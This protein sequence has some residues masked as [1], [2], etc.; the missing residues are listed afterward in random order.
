VTEPA[1]RAVAARRHV[2][3]V[4]F[5]HGLLFA[6]WTAHIPHLQARL[7]LSDAGLG[8]ALLGAPIGSVLAVGSVA[9]LLTRLGSRRTVQLTLAGYSLAG[10]LVAVAGSPLALAAGLAVWG[11]CQGALDVS[12]NTQG[13]AVERAL[14]RPI[15]SGLHAGWSLGAF[16]GAG[17]GALAVAAGVSLTVQLLVLGPLAGAVALLMPGRLL[18]DPAPASGAPATR[19]GVAL[20]SGLVWLLGAIALAGLLCEG[21]AADWSAVELR[22]VTGAVPGIAGLGYAAFAAAMFLVRVAGDRLLDR[23][24]PRALVPGLLIVAA[25]GM[26]VALAVRTPGPTLAGLACLGAGIGLVSPA[27]FSAAG[28]LPGI[29]TGT[30]VA[31]VAAI[32]WTGF[33]GGP[34]LIGRLAQISSLPI[35]L[36]LVP[37][38]CAAIAVAIRTTDA[39]APPGSDG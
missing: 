12:M 30:G 34:P 27:A 33:V 19:R 18:A 5:V 23:L 36:G 21:A 39:F 13:I 25:V 1:G 6:S 28:R 14:G 10:L 38:L 29:A 15:L 2:L 37:L 32:G 20:R 9:P 31:T 7:G 16:A 26:T 22:T 17:A 3:V 4:F 11:A 8:L 24:A 35:A